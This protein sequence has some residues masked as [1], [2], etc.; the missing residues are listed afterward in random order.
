[1]EEGSSKGLHER[2]EDVPTSVATEVNSDKDPAV[3]V[4]G[5]VAAHPLRKLL[6]AHL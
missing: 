4:S 3:P 2:G 5:T 6:P 1:M